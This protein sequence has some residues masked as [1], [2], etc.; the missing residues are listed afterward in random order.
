MSASSSAAQLNHQET[1]DARPRQHPAAALVPDWRG[2]YQARRS[3]WRS[4]PKLLRFV[5]AISLAGLIG[6]A[7]AL[8]YL[9]LQDLKQAD[10]L[11]AQVASQQA[12][13]VTQGLMEDT[14]ALVQ[15]VSPL[16]TIYV[17]DPHGMSA[18]TRREHRREI[19]AAMD[20]SP[21]SGLVMINSLGD[22]LFEIGDPQTANV[23]LWAKMPLESGAQLL[24]Q[25]VEFMRPE[26]DQGLQ[27]LFSLPGGEHALSAIVDA[28]SLAAALTPQF[29]DIKAVYLSDSTGRVLA[30]SIAAERPDR[31]NAE[32]NQTAATAN[33]QSASI[34]LG[35]PGLQVMAVA[36]PITMARFLNRFGRVLGASLGLT[37]LTVGL[38]IYVIQNEWQKH[39]RRASLDED[40]VARSEIAADIMGAGIIDWRVSDAVISY[41]EGWQHLFSVGE[42][43]DDEEI[44]DWIDKLH[45]DSKDTARANYQALIDGRVFEIEHE[46]KIR[47]RDGDYVT[48]RERGRA[49]MN[50]SGRTSRIVL[51]QRKTR[52]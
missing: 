13:V 45:P 5:I 43:T 24:D 17:A 34:A 19:F 44:Y 25:Q 49:R 15:A 23:A 21:V 50:A 37:F 18:S 22:V 42:P 52:A 38:L 48:V 2:R 8:S 46:I 14:Q 3:Q 32:L 36:A 29:S 6:A 41:S 28:D 47:R 27:V 7:V 10:Q 39:D 33:T 16:L 31:L 1:P 4:D 20:D 35:T 12:A 11:R 51:V 30:A 9:L 26:R 40:V